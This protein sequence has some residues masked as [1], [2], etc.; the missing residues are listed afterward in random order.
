MLR[1]Q[2]LP[3]KQLD[4][5]GQKVANHSGGYGQQN[6]DKNNATHFSSPIRHSP[7]CKKT[8]ALFGY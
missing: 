2:S 3:L 1:A 5:L 8:Q 7:A 4:Y 6:K